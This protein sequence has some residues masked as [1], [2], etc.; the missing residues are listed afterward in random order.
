VA[1]LS[2]VSNAEVNN[3]WIVASTPPG[4]FYVAVGSLGKNCVLIF[5][6]LPALLEEVICIR[7][8]VLSL[9]YRTQ[10]NHEE[11]LHSVCMSRMDSQSSRMQASSDNCLSA[12]E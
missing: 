9:I 5:I 10:W 6:F 4:F 8:I 2:P 1:L 7:G 11:L 3:T 12:T